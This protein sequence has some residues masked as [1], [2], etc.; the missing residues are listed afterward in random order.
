MTATVPRRLSVLLVEDE[1]PIREMVAE[2]LTDSGLE[3]HAVASA[4]EALRHLARGEPCDIL[5]TDVDLG[6]R[7]DGGGLSRLARALRPGLPVVYASGTV[8]G[9]QCLEAVPDASF[10]P[11]PYRLETV[12][13]MLSSIAAGPAQSFSRRQTASG[14]G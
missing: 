1:I 7:V 13:A 2:A 5:F 6:G 10:V 3:V 4:A 9:L 8:A 11:K 12:C 14:S